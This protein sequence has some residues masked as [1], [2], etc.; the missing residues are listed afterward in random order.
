MMQDDLRPAPSQ[1]TSPQLGAANVRRHTAALRGLAFVLVGQTIF[2]LAYINYFCRAFRIDRSLIWIHVPLAAGLFI[3]STIAPGFLLYNRRFRE[4]RIN[5]YLLIVLPAVVST[6]VALLY[7]T[8]FASNVWMGLNINHK[9]LALFLGDWWAGGDILYLSKWVWV[10]LAAFALAM[11]A[12]YIGLAKTLFRGLSELL[13]PDSPNSLFVTR[14][15]A[16]KSAIAIGL[17]LLAYSGF[18]Y[19]LAQRTPY[20]ELLSNDP[21]LSVVR[22][23][24]DVYD[25]GYV[26]SINRLKLEEPRNRASYPAGQKFDKKN[27]VIIIVDSLRA[28]HTQVYGYERPTTPFLASLYAAGRLR[29]VEFATSTCAESNCGI[30]STL[31]S[32]TL[33][34]QI[35]ENFKLYDLL[36]DQGYKTY[37]ILSGNHDWQGLKE[38]YGHEMDLYFDGVNS[39]RYSKADDRLIFEGLERVPSHEAGPAFFYIHLM[40]AHL[41]GLKQDKYK[42]YQPSAV[43]NDW[44]ALFKGEYDRETVVNNYDNG[45][46]QADATIREVFATLQQKGYLQNSIVMILA[47]HG[48]GL[49]DR[50]SSGYGHVSSLHQEFIRIPLLIYDDS[51]AVYGNLKFGT[52]IDVAPTIVDR[53][54]LSIPQSWEGSSL[55]SPAI[56]PLNIHQTSLRNPC[57]AVIYRTDTAI[58]K[59]ISCSLGRTEELYELVS[60][61]KEQHNLI[62]SAEPALVQRMRDEVARQK[63]N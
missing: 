34:H 24:T 53:L 32:R 58:H 18:L 33:R 51:S 5:R 16:L 44:S 30:L 37:F 52:Q 50:G 42:L 60:D 43:K 25:Q 8:D 11:F 56:K 20:S 57:Y 17:L 39:T 26:A 14:R 13:L 47:D 2:S 27:V 59:Y 49:G 38:S 21:F 7:V 28:D 54:G 6:A 4:S 1:P 46:T 9:L 63:S 35:P 45:V 40:S 61:P 15:R 31:F 41:I 62:D 48:E 29:K 22:S 36:K 12:A 23:T 10:G 19:V 3:I 55:L